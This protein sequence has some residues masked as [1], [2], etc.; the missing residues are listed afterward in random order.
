LQ[1]YEDETVYKYTGTYNDGGITG[2]F[3]LQND[4]TPEDSPGNFFEL[5]VKKT[6]WEGELNDK[7]RCD[8]IEMWLHFDEDGIFGL[9]KEAGKE[10]IIGGQYN[11]ETREVYFYRTDFAQEHAK[12]FHGI[13]DEVGELFIV[14]GD[15]QNYD[16]DTNHHWGKFELEGNLYPGPLALLD[17]DW[18]EWG[19]DFTAK[20]NWS[21]RFEENGQ[22]F[23]MQIDHMMGKLGT[24]HLEGN[25]VDHVGT[26]TIAGQILLDKQ[27]NINTVFFY[28]KYQD[29]RQISYKGTLSCNDWSIKGTYTDFDQ[30]TGNFELKSDENDFCG[31]E[32]DDDTGKSINI[33]MKGVISSKGV[34]GMAIDEK[35]LYFARGELV[36]DMRWWV[37]ARQYVGG[38]LTLYAGRFNVSDGVAY[39]KGIW[40][41]DGQ[42]AV[43]TQTVMFEGKF[44]DGL[45]VGNKAI[46]KEYADYQKQKQEE[47]KAQLAKQ[48][49]EKAQLAKQ[50]EEKAQLAKQEE[51]KAQL[52]KQEEE[53]A[54]LAKQEEE[55]AQL[56]KQEEEPKA[57]A[58]PV[59]E[60]KADAG[61]VEEPKADAGPV[62][63]PKAD[64]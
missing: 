12:F 10:V 33:D 50:E 3:L 13:G 45:P 19:Q 47:E 2:K 54:Q 62:E 14:K 46:I 64:V 40:R 34:Y 52:A 53:K 43:T 55:K 25:G 8:D 26:F 20:V 31:Q 35:G 44:G 27:E 51:E 49:E 9:G 58:G 6:R 61:P 17:E 60:P 11:R 41:K 22:W 56:A 21:G 28:K 16:E 5:N 18:T 30:K 7:E 23:R 32:T 29:G 4:D 24:N 1:T 48:E 63:E 59:E 15:W 36:T 39:L 57:D 42:G 38:E 37:M